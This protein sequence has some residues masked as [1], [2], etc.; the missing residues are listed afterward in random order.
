MVPFAKSGLPHAAWLYANVPGGLAAAP[1][2]P[3]LP[4]TSPPL[5]GAL[6]SRPLASDRARRHIHVAHALWRLPCRQP[7]SPGHR[8][9]GSDGGM[10]THYCEGVSFKKWFFFVS[11][12]GLFG[13]NGIVEFALA[14]CP[15]G[16]GGMVPFAKSGLPHAAWSFANV[17]GGLAAAPLTSPPLRGALHSRPLPSGRA[18]RHIHVAHALWRLPCRQPSSPGH[19]VGGSDG[20]M[21]THHCG[22]ICLKIMSYLA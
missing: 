4:L 22:G 16:F 21:K 3:R 9:G 18:R 14:A 10:E 11:G 6:H 19:R 1:W 13:V 2:R 15:G 20:G 5:R 7:S 17:P 12:M 8:V